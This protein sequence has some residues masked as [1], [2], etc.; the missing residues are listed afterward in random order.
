MPHKYNKGDYIR[1]IGGDIDWLEDVVLLIVDIEYNSH[2]DNEGPVNWYHVRIPPD[3]R[4]HF[5]YKSIE[6]SSKWRLA[7]KAEIL[8]YG[9]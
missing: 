7:N 3:D 9:P 1:Y 2:F 4:D 6:D 8:L 5:H